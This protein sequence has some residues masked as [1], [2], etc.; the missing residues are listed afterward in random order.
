[1]NAAKCAWHTQS[2]LVKSTALFGCRCQPLHRL[3]RKEGGGRG[4]G[5]FL[6]PFDRIDRVD[7]STT[8][9]VQYIVRDCIAVHIVDAACNENQEKGRKRKSLRRRRD[10]GAGEAGGGKRRGCRVAASCNEL[11]KRKRSHVILNEG[12]LR[13]LCPHPPLFESSF[14]ISLSLSLTTSAFFSFPSFPVSAF[15]VPPLYSFPRLGARRLESL[16]I[17]ISFGLVCRLAARHRDYRVPATHLGNSGGPLSAARSS[18]TTFFPLKRARDPR[19]MTTD[20]VRSGASG[21]NLPSPPAAPR[22]SS[23]FSSFSSS[24]FSFTFSFFPH[25]SSAPFFLVTL[26]PLALFRSPSLSSLLFAVSFL[27]CL[28]IEPALFLFSFLFLSFQFC[29]ILFILSLLCYPPLPLLLSF[30]SFRWR[31]YSLFFGCLFLLHS[32][33]VFLSLSP[34]LPCSASLAH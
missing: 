16:F 32:L 24:S 31:C 8:K 29:L 27:L 18:P 2:I 33:L 5:A 15:G 4:R 26:S 3:Y 19:R 11:H 6:R 30:L 12:L 20:G 23:S 9:G 28:I 1:M 25:R 10:A 21:T 7:R 13:L 22:P 14:L 17:F 34:S